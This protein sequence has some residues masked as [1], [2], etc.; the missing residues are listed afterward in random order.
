MYNII[1]LVVNTYMT[2][3]VRMC[4]V[5]VYTKKMY[6]HYTLVV[7]LTII[8]V[9]YRYTTPT[10]YLYREGTRVIKTLRDKGYTM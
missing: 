4:N 5:Y 3:Y 7:R 10:V 2:P 8:V 1:L 6:T 9:G